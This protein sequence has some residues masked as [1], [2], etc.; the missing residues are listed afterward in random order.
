MSGIACH[1]C[2]VRPLI[3]TLVLLLAALSVQAQDQE[4]KLM[5]RLMRPNMEQEYDTRQSRFGNR[6]SVE[7]KSARSK[8][9]LFQQ[10][11]NPGEYRSKAYGGTKTAWTGEFQ[12]GTKQA[13]TRGK[14]EMVNATRV[15]PVKTKETTDARE[16]NKGAPTRDYAVRPFLK[17]GRSQD[18]LDAEGGLPKDNKPIGWTGD[19]L[20]PMTIDEVRE[21]LNKSK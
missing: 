18:R 21:L 3:A 6:S 12:Q 8:G 16:S 17:R 4:R 19:K 15:V 1:L 7:Q 11:V 13:A 9:F 10:K 14:Y 2:R 5:E 20:E